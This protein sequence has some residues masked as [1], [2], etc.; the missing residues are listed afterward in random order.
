MQYLFEDPK[1]N[2]QD[3]KLWTY[4]LRNISRVFRDDIP[5]AYTLQTLLWSLR[6]AGT[7]L[8]WTHNGFKFIPLTGTHFCWDSAEEFEEIKKKYLGP[9]ST[10]IITLLNELPID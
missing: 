9:F 5:K 2:L 3:T 10:E 7:M 4:L 1:P 8:R 6:N